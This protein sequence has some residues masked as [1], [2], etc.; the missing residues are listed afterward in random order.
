[1][2]PGGST[3]WH[4]VNETTLLYL[5]ERDY[6]NNILPADLYRRLFITGDHSVGEYHLKITDIRKSDEGKY[7]CTV[8]GKES[9]IYLTV[10]GKFG[11]IYEHVT[12]N[13]KTLPC[14]LFHIIWKLH[15][16]SVQQRSQKRPV[17][18]V[19]FQKPNIHVRSLVFN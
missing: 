18:N 14:A 17:D 15:V 16:S 7:R 5:A 4:Y 6:V 19:S 12:Y 9:D 11:N 13:Y 2:A 10:I 1:M 3:V 8:I